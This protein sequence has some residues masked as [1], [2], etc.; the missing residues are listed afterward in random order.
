LVG[1]KTSVSTRVSPQ[2]LSPVWDEILPPL[3]GYF[4]SNDVL[5]VHVLD[6]A[7]NSV[8]GAC[9][10]TLRDLPLGVTTERTLSLRKCDRTGKLS[11]KGGKSGAAGSLACVF[12]LAWPGEPAFT[13][14]PWR[15]PL[16][17]ADIEFVS[18]S[19]L[20]G[21]SP[22]P[23]VIL[24]LTP[25]LNAQKMKTKT[26]EATNNPTWRDT[27][28]VLLG[29]GDI[30][31]VM[32]YDKAS[33]EKLATGAIHLTEFAVGE[34]QTRASPLKARERGELNSGCEHYLRK[35]RRP[36]R[37]DRGRMPL[38]VA[39]VSIVAFNRLHWVHR[40]LTIA[41]GVGRE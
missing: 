5:I 30:M 21:V 36:K 19:G 25:S 26:A 18:A 11:K 27:K 40:M 14:R 41:L 13:D 12:S 7:Q 3:Q 4:I 10:L 34:T 20:P 22:A 24:K 1:G 15:W 16:L 23:Y 6:T 37:P 29:E 9:E 28:T 2:T 39:R 35:P 32:I 8:I 33:N 31:L 38:R 17:S